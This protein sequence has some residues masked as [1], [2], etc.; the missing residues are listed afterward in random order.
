MTQDDVMEKSG[1]NL[2]QVGRMERGERNSS[3][4]TVK[5]YA[6]ALGLHI[7][8]LFDFEMPEKSVD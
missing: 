7:R 6:D 4:S 1:L 5:L 3:I 8:E 2:R